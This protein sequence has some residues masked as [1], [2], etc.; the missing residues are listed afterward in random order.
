M[1]GEDHGPFTAQE[2]I[3]WLLGS[4]IAVIGALTRWVFMDTRKR[5]DEVDEALT[6]HIAENSKDF[7]R[8]ASIEATMLKVNEE[9]RETSQRIE[10]ALIRLHER[11]DK[12]LED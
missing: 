7:Q 12:V 3:L 11:L 4:A 5:I 6:S 9:R 1:A 10:D 8:L 2:V